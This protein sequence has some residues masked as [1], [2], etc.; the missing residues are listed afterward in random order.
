MPATEKPSRDQRVLHMVFAGTSVV[1]LISTFL[2]FAQDHYRPWKPF[3]RQSRDIE[4][5]ISQ[6]R[7][8]TENSRENQRARDEIEAELGTVRSQ[9]IPADFLEYFQHQVK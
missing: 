5:R 6:W 7:L 3:Q 9:G 2:M 1:M 4:R 8:D